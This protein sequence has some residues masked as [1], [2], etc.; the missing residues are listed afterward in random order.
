MDFILFVTVGFILVFFYY[1]LHCIWVHWASLY[2]CLCSVGFTFFCVF[3][4]LLYFGTL[5]FKQ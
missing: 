1:E 5:G 4:T 3:W 2:L